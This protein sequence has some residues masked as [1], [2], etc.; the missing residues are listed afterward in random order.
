[1][2][3]HG[4]EETAALQSQQFAEIAAECGSVDFRWTSDAAERNKL[5]KARHDAYWASR[6]LAPHLDGLSTDVCVPISRLA[7]CVVETQRDI[8]EN[9]FLAPIVGHAGDGNFHVLILFD[10]K[11]A[12]SVAKTEAF[13]ARLN[14]RAIAMDG[15]CTG[16]HGI[17]QGKM[18][19]LAE[20]A[21]NALDVMRAIKTSLDPDNI[22]NP[23]KL[24][25][26]V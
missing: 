3:F 26:L 10:G 6:A 24:F 1:V 19:F 13:V 21:G 2:E 14:R 7:D 17:G 25:R 8:K 16:E 23:G 20:E 15:T 12:E 11:D 5:W 18:S 4:T 22:F 9:G